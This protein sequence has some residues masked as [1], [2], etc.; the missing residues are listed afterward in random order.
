MKERY[1]YKDKISTSWVSLWYLS[2]PPHG[3][4]IFQSS[5]ASILCKSLVD[6]SNQHLGSSWI[7]I[8]ELCLTMASSSDLSSSIP[9]SSMSNP[10]SVYLSHNSKHQKYSSNQAQTLYLS[11]MVWY[12]YSLLQVLQTHRYHRWIW[13]MSLA[14]ASRLVS[15]SWIWDM[16]WKRSQSLD[17]VELYSFWRDHTFHC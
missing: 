14:S 10:N 5:S 2:P 16:V 6:F 4:L 3:F 15:Q 8:L 12:F 17:L 13:A 9:N 11:S 1:F 7:L